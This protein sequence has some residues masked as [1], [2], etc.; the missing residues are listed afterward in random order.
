MIANQREGKLELCDQVDRFVSHATLLERAGTSTTT[1]R[2]TKNALRSMRFYVW[3]HE[4]R[5]K[6][7]AP[8]MHFLEFYYY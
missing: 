1:S 6:S 3:L 7:L 2:R 8:L 5:Q 4:C